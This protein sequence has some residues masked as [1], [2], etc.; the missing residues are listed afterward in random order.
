MKPKGPGISV[1]AVP[2]TWQFTPEDMTDEHL[3]G[4]YEGRY[5]SMNEGDDE[6]SQKTVAKER[7]IA[8]LELIRRG[9]LKII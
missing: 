2:A 8:R 9:I 6:E 4:F 5:D 1:L 3:L 7:E